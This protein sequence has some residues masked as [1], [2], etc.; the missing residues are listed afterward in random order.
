[1]FELVSLLTRMISSSHNEPVMST[2]R[3]N[4]ERVLLVYNAYGDGRRAFPTETH[5]SSFSVGLRRVAGLRTNT[6]FGTALK[7]NVV[8]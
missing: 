4:F 8:L 6:M 3:V 1:M 7:R 5:P 2:K